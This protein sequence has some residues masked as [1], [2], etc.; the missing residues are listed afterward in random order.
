MINSVNNGYGIY[1]STSINRFHTAPVSQVRPAT[2]QVNNYRYNLYGNALDAE[3]KQFINQYQNQYQSLKK[4]AT[5]LDAASSNSVWNKYEGVSS[6]ADTLTV[7]TQYS[8]KQAATYEVEVKQLAQN[9]VNESRPMPSNEA[10]AIVSGKLTLKT[11]GREV[12]I[13]VDAQEKTNQQV[14]NDLAKSIN[15]QKVGV[16]A[17][18]ITKDQNSYLEVSADQA[19]K[20]NSFT[21]T[22]AGN[23]LEQ[24]GLNTVKQQGQNTVANITK[25]GDAASVQTV[26][27]TDNQ[28]A[29]DSYRI[30]A[31]LKDVGKATVKV[32]VNADELVK[33]IKDMVNSHNDTVKLLNDNAGK[34][35]AVTK[36][37]GNLLLP[38]ISEKSMATMGISYKDDGRL[39]FDEETFKTAFDKDPSQSKE[40]I[41]SSYSVSRGLINDAQQALKES[42]YN[43]VNNAMAER[44]TQINTDPLNFVNSY[45]K[46]GGYS[47]LNANYIGFLF[48]SFA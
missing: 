18:V 29:I 25:N 15:A 27:S 44:Q 9:Q 10:S 30:S 22:D 13:N 4:A 47:A 40:I 2:N 41:G 38:P 26:Q 31:T 5:N 36:Q 46:Y 6:N 37:L 7:N 17:K 19:G 34:G 12:Q 35:T 33:N 45:S 48:N 32:D 8:P 24:T 39:T 43:L 21:F 1:G 42:S 20:N 11:A 16:T 23:I 3:S 28:I 14:L